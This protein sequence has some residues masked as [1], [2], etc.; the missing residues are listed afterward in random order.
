MQFSKWRHERPQLHMTLGHCLD[1]WSFMADN[2]VVLTLARALGL[3]LGIATLILGL[4]SVLTSNFNWCPTAQYNECFGPSLRWNNGGTGQGFVD[5]ANRATL[6]VENS[7]WRSI[8]TFNPEFFFPLWGPVILG[9]ITI[10]QHLKGRAWAI[11]R[12]WPRVRS[13]AKTKRNEN[14]LT[15]TRRCSFTLCLLG[16]LPIWASKLLVKFTLGHELTR[17]LKTSTG[18]LGVLIGFFSIF[19]AG[20]ALLISVAGGTNTRTHFEIKIKFLDQE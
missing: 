10:L 14:R 17:Y 16:S 7:G 5:D 11:Y 18:S 13:G 3:G 9:Y 15:K 19:Q 1:R 6:G 2:E 12:T 8:F 4:I 20:L